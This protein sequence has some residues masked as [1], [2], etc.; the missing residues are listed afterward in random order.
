[1]IQPSTTLAMVI[2][3]DWKYCLLES[4]YSYA[5]VLKP[6]GQNVTALASTMDLALKEMA[7]RLI[8]GSRQ[9]RLRNPKRK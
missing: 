5:A 2:P 4:M 9:V 7:N 1:M 3:K 8:S 6:L